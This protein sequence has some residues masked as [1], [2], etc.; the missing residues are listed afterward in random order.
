MASIVTQPVSA[1][2]R[3]TNAGDQRRDG[4]RNAAPSPAAARCRR[5]VLTVP[6][7]PRRQCRRVSGAT[8]DLDSKHLAQHSCGNRPG[9]WIV[10]FDFIRPAVDCHAIAPHWR[11]SSASRQPA[12]LARAIDEAPVRRERQRGHLHHV[13]RL[14][15]RD[16]RRQRRRTEATLVFRLVD[17]LPRRCLFGG[18]RVPGPSGS[19]PG[20]QGVTFA[21]REQPRRGQQI[22]QR[23]EAGDRRRTAPPSPRGDPE[24]RLA[25][26]VTWPYSGML[27]CFFGSDGTCLS[28]RNAKA[29][30]I[31]DR[32]RGDR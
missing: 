1:L 30:A 32:S 21:L 4:S 28:F 8:L 18:E 7:S 2:H 23:D 13:T 25:F 24:H 27:P 31:R 15:T 12:E 14:R 17:V 19:A 16:R 11:A 20:P 22:H 3:L 29:P 10:D 6:F 26:L 5:P 9:A